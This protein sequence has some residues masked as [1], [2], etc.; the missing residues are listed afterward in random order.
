MELAKHNSVQLIRVPGH[1]GIF[2]NET[3]DQLAKL[4][5]ECLFIGPEPACSISVGSCQRSCQGQTETKKK[6]WK[7]LIGLK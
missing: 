3:V 6:G 2:G 4:K 7:F 1:E 5:S